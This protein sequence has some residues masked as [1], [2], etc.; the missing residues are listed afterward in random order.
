MAD[1]TKRIMDSGAVWVIA[2]GM[3][4]SQLCRGSLLPLRGHLLRDRVVTPPRVG[5]LAFGGP[6]VPSPGNEAMA[7]GGGRRKLS[8]PPP[9][10]SPGG[11]EEE[12]SGGPGSAPRSILAAGQAVAAGRSPGENCP[13]AS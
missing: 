9:G 12:G 2:L 6:D 13:M 1:R 11:A 10:A 8:S 4:R 7:G 5:R 3:S